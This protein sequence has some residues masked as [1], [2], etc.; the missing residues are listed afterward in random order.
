MLEKRL[1]DT[2][3]YWNKFKREIKMTG[4]IVIL[5]GVA[6]VQHKQIYKLLEFIQKLAENQSR[7]IDNYNDMADYV[8][9]LIRDGKLQKEFDN[10]VV[11]CLEELVNRMK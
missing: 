9:L 11:N 2:K 8:N 1:D 7:I 6:I 3:N 4:W 10:E 5:T